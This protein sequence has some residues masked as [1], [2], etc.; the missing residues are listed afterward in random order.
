MVALR[1]R[2]MPAA[3]SEASPAGRA[4]VALGANLGDARRNV[5]AAAAE[6]GRLPGTRLVRL[7]SLYR[8]APVGYADQ[9]DFINAVA[10]LHTALGARDLLR[11]LLAIE[12]A[13]GRERSFANA[14]RVLD[15]DLLLHGAE[16]LDD[17]ELRLP[18]PRM[19]ERAFVMAPLAEIAP[20]LQV[21]GH[22]TAAELARALLAAQ[23]QG[24]SRL[25]D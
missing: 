11:A 16:R 20:A 4:F 9:P 17:D 21:P 6:L 19:H 22:G 10:E 14:P 18:H 8:T 12:H 7:S 2:R 15:L 1:A 25:E 23:G 24:I 13:H 3:T 5:L